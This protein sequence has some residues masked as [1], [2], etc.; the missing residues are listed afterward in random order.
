MG[1]MGL[2]SKNTCCSC[3]GNECG[4]LHLQPEAHSPPVGPAT[5]NPSSG[6]LR[7]PHTCPHTCIHTRVHTDTF[8]SESITY[9]LK[10]DT[11]KQQQAGNGEH[12]GTKLHQH[13]CP[14]DNTRPLY[15]AGSLATAGGKKLYLQ[16]SSLLCNLLLLVLFIHQQIVFF[17]LRHILWVN[18]DLYKYKLL[19]NK[20][21]PSIGAQ[22]SKFVCYKAG[23]M[24]QQHFFFLQRTQV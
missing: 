12:F 19:L 18:I 2:V 6:L 8:L 13:L 5:G 7:Y 17:H 10:V 1:E 15:Q 11:Q 9:V 23:E 3:L 14:S 24:V 20:P 21:L 4:S 16:W 22:K